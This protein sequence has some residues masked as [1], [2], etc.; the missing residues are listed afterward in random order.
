MLGSRDPWLREFD[1]AK[2]LGNDTYQLLQTAKDEKDAASAAR[3]TAATRRKLQALT[4]KIEHL[5]A[6]AGLDESLSSREADR[7]R[8]M[9]SRLKTQSSQL[10]Q[11]LKQRQLT[12]S[13]SGSGA[14]GAKPLET[15]DTAERD[16]HGLLVLQQDIIKRASG[17]GLLPQPVLLR[18]RCPQSKT[19][20]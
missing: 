5:D 17:T 20:R 19:T 16:E 10:A 12:G 13:A 7:R 14:A 11:L 18:E 4:T 3:H 8:D 6:T 9:V 1:D 2:L 15:I